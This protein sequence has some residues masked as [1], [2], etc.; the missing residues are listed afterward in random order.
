MPMGTGIQ[1][2]RRRGPKSR[3]AGMAMEAKNSIP[4]PAVKLSK[5]RSPSQSRRLLLPFLPPSCIGSA[6]AARQKRKTLAG[7]AATQQ[8]R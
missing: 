8:A 1:G 2:A 4:A 7:N 3:I 5:Y 6:E